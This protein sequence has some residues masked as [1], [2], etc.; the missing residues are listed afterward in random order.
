MNDY[1]V[2]DLK[3]RVD[4][5]DV[6]SNRYN[7]TL[8]RENNEHVACCPFHK[9][10]TPSFKVNGPKQFYYCFGCGASGSVLDF[11]IEYENLDTKPAIDRLKEFAGVSEQTSAPVAK[12]V[13]RE[14]TR[15]ADPSSLWIPIMPVPES[16]PKLMQGGKTGPIYN[17]KRTSEANAYVQYS[18]E[19]DGVYP[20]R[21]TDGHLLGAVLRIMIQDQKI[22]PAVTYCVNVETGEE[23]WCLKGLPEPKP[24]YNI[25]RWSGRDTVLL[26][27]GES[28]VDAAQG[29]ISHKYDIA[30]W[31]NGTNAI[32]KVDWSALYGRNVILWADNDLKLFKRGERTGQVKPQDE[33]NGR[34]AMLWIKR[35]LEA[36]GSTCALLEQPN[37]KPDGWDCKD[38][39]EEGRD[40]EQYILDHTPALDSEPVATEPDTEQT[41]E[42]EPETPSPDANKIIK[43]LG[44]SGNL[45]YYYSTQTQQLRELK[46]AEHTENRMLG[47][48]D[49]EWFEAHFPKKNGGFDVSEAANWMMSACRHKGIFDPLTIRGRGCWMDDGRFVIHLGD[50]LIV[51]GVTTPIN[52]HK[53]HYVYQAARRIQAPKNALSDEQA[54]A[55]LDTAKLFDWEMPASGALLAGWV[56]LAPLCSSLKWRPHIWLTG[57]SGSGKSSIVEYYMKPLIGDMGMLTSLNS[58]EAGV[59]RALKSDGMPVIV[60]EFD[61]KSK[62]TQD[63]AQSYFD[64]MRIASN[65]SGVKVYRATTGEGATSFEAHSMFCL[66]GIQICT[67]EQAILNRTAKLTLRTKA[68]KTKEDKAANEKEWREVL[69]ALESSVLGV[70][71]VSSR[72]FARTAGMIGVIQ[73]NIE[74]FRKA[75]H[76]HFGIARHADQYGTL[77]AGAYSLVSDCKIQ[78]D[79]A[80][81]YIASFDWSSYTD[82]TETDEAN[83]ALSAIL[84]LPLRVEGHSVVRTKS[85]G[86]WIEYVKNNRCERDDALTADH[87][88]EALRRAG[89]RCRDNDFVV[90]NQSKVFEQSLRDQP[91]GMNW[92]RYLR[93]IIDSNGEQLKGTESMAFSS[94][95]KARGT[96]VGYEFVEVDNGE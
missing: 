12:P 26:V 88:D 42:T 91:W 80:L 75:A 11:I 69:A 95:L 32:E 77:L 23:A 83:A 67:N 85:I 72:L 90:S 9:E 10:K 17:P 3:Q 70:E 15:E 61:P 81:R 4:I 34:K 53:S 14:T 39:V 22:T 79:V 28:C 76:K 48:A 66:V 49:R 78:E 30:S 37:D 74:V 89:I 47:M 54:R 38:A 6:I 82:D 52:D 94:G 84:Q 20:Y 62:Q 7:I 5:V 13:Q 63:K 86:E 73:H 21:N 96:R 27:E 35:H 31:P 2:E 33:Q 18:P 25:D 24:L 8:K 92:G 44:Y 57:L 45:Y 59:R 19:P 64:L 55:L 29:K 50:R 41:D 16:A 56:V 71:D 46:D 60:E 68:S 43:P 87:A 1:T 65:D 58:T 51:D 93:R 36:N 40:L